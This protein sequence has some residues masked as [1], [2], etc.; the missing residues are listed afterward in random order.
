[1]AAKEIFRFDRFEF[2]A[3]QGVAFRDGQPLDLPPKAAKLLNLLLQRPGRVLAKSELI[4]SVW[5]NVIVEEGNLA[6]LVFL[7]RREFGESSIETVS[8]RGYRFSYPVSAMSSED[9][10]VVA[11]LPF[12]DLSDEKSEGSLCEGISEEVLDRLSLVAGLRVVARNSSFAMASIDVREI[13]RKLSANLVI[14]GSIRKSGNQL[15][16]SVRIVETQSALLRWSV[17][18]DR[19]LIDVFKI[20]DEIASAVIQSILPGTPAPAPRSAIGPEA[21]QLYLQGRYHWNRRP[22]PEVVKALDC[23]ERALELE[24][25]FPAAWAGVA[26]VHATLGSWEA[27]VLEPR[28][29][30]SKATESARRALNLDPNLVEAHATLAYTTLHYHGDIPGAEQKFSRALGLNPNY[31]SARHWHSHCLVA[32]GK[33]DQALDESNAALALDP[34]NILLSVHLAWH[35]HMARDYGQVVTQAERVAQMEPHYHWARYFLAWGAEGL[36][37]FSRAVSEMRKA[38]EFSSNNP[39]MIAGLAR[40]YASAGKRKDT[41][42]TLDRLELIRN[43]RE[44][45]AYEEALVW[46]ALHEQDQALLMI[47]KAVRDRSGWIAYLDVDPRLDPVRQSKRFAEIRALSGLN[48]SSGNS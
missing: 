21:Y 24:P 18:F 20:Q 11:V 10:V 48:S 4:S 3:T 1:M 34:M 47:E 13:G 44:L 25:N 46:L 15:R 6:K 5:S 2:D 36:G 40:A 26:D 19:P 31:A 28:K 39:V 35:H 9:R 17:T 42:K 37:D 12:S 33:F 43:G 23:F 7:L 8:K 16:I 14:E 32:A 38:V 30:E 29:A 41:L 22:G 45:F 27:G